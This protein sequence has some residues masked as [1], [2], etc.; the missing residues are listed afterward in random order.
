MHH[1]AV[2]Y[3]VITHIKH[4]T[5]I[6]AGCLKLQQPLEARTQVVRDAP[7]TS[8]QAKRTSVQQC[9]QCHIWQR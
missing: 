2:C 4:I 9:H 6:P 3:E 5:H 8:L 7:T 1:A